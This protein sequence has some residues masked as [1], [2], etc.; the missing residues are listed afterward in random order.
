MKTNEQV[1]TTL[2]APYEEL[3]GIPIAD[4][5]QDVTATVLYYNGWGFVLNVLPL[6]FACFW[7]SIVLTGACGCPLG[8]AKAATFFGVLTFCWIALN[9]IVYSIASMVFRGSEPG[10]IIGGDLLF[11]AEGNDI[12]GTITNLDVYMPMTANY[13]DIIAVVYLSVF[14]LIAFMHI[15]VAVWKHFKAEREAE[16]EEEKLA[17]ASGI[18]SG[19][20]V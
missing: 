17:A 14:G 12:S 15:C 18:R 13:M 5:G 10:L 9:W 19:S 4:V 8:D 7:G 3:D 20:R 16:E 11:D 6:I 2:A 1:C